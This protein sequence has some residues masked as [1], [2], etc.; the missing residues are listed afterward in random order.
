VGIARFFD[1]A[2]EDQLSNR[3]KL[4]PGSLIVAEE[5]DLGRLTPGGGCPASWV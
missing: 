4:D 3:C 1:E 5:G 2:A